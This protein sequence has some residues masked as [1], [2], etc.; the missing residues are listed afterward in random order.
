MRATRR[1]D[2]LPVVLKIRS[3]LRYSRNMHSLNKEYALMKHIDS[4]Y[5]LKAYE[6]IEIVEGRDIYPSGYGLM[7]DLIVKK[8]SSEYFDDHRIMVLVIE[9]FGGRSLKEVAK[10][11]S[12]REALQISVLIS[13]ALIDIH[14]A[15]IIHHVLL[16]SLLFSLFPLSFSSSFLSLFI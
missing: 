5:C 9:D 1:V 12:V 4:P 3:Q 14:N 6:I 10:T 13:K 11:I 7:V 2:N 16:F 8:F 15:N